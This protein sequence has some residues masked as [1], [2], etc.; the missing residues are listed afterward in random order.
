VHN[1]LAVAALAADGLRHDKFHRIP[2][3]QHQRLP[4]IPLEE[5]T[6]HLRHHRSSTDLPLSHVQTR[7][8]QRHL[9]RRRRVILD[10]H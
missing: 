3:P 5:V 6:R 7:L 4:P 9:P 2:D 10:S 1:P 8:L